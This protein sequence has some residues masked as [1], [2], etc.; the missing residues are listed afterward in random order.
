MLSSTKYLSF[1]KLINITPFPIFTWFKWIDN[2]MTCWFEIFSTVL[3]YWRIA[4]ANMTTSS[5]PWYYQRNAVVS[6][7]I[8][9]A[10]SRIKIRNWLDGVGYSSYWLNTVTGGIRQFIGKRQIG[11]WDVFREISGVYNFSAR[12]LIHDGQFLAIFMYKNWNI[13]IMEMNESIVWIMTGFIS[14]LV[15]MEVAWRL[16][17]THARKVSVME[18]EV[19][20]Q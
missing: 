6:I 15:L 5:S 1:H 20:I 2:G 14:T 7:V 10:S 9:C 8:R 11:W 17:K 13:Y 4:T 18:Q 16:A 3:V 12:I 19:K